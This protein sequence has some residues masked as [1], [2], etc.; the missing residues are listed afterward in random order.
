MAAIVNPGSDPVGSG[1]GWT[2]TYDEALAEARRWLASMH[3]EGMTDVSLDVCDGEERDG[4][5]RFGFRHAVTGVTVWLETPGVDDVDAYQKG[6]IFPPRVYWNGS[7]SDTPK[8]E[9]W[10][11]PGF[12]AVRTYKAAS[13]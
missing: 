1:E 10:E 6:R 8:L 2:N 7:S 5:W 3:A 12:V 11:A 4:R 9:D 13:A